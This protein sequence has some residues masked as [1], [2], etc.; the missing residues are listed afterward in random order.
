[1]RIISKRASSRQ[2]RGMGSAGARIANWR[3]GF[4]L[5]WV[6]AMWCATGDCQDAEELA[7]AQVDQVAAKSGLNGDALMSTLSGGWRR[8]VM[9][10]RAWPALPTLLLNRPIIWI[11]M[12]SAGSRPMISISKS[13]VFRQLTLLS[14]VWQR[15]S[16][17]SIAGSYAFGP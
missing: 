10:G 2:R 14:A 11:S 1:M 6:R 7:A 4:A 16:S 3:G 13:P 12:P 15:G 8:R 9:L 5:A 17:N